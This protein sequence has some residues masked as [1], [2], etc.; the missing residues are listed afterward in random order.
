MLHARR[1]ARRPAR[2][3]RP[4]AS[5]TTSSTSRSRSGQHVIDDFVR[6]VP[7]GPDADSVHALQQRTQVRDAAR[8][9]RTASAP[10]T[11]RRG[12]TPGSR[13]TTG[14]GRHVLRRGVDPDKDQSYFLFS[15][16]QEQLS[17]AMFPVGAHDEG[18]GAE[19]TRGGAGSR[20]PRSADS[21]EICFVPGRRLR[22]L[23]RAR[24]PAR[25]RERPPASSPT[26]S[27]R[28]LGRHDGIHRFTVGQ[29]KRLR[30][31]RL[32][33]RC[34]VTAIDAP[35][36]TVVVGPREALERTRFDVSDVNWIAGDA[37]VAP[38][39]VARADPPPAPRGRGHGRRDR[40]ASG[41]TWSSTNRSRRSR[42]ARPRSSTT[43][44][45][46]LGGAGF[47]SQSSV[48]SFRRPVAG[49]RAPRASLEH[50]RYARRVRARD[51]RA[52]AASVE[53]GRR[54]FTPADG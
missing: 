53:Q 44:T 35:S 40:L 9:R 28:V 5:R 52:E 16:T 46:C 17:R 27:G 29:R 1:P 8:A 4:S 3:R 30:A 31:R 25:R 10:R 23:R 50:A 24:R 39:R 47:S 21:H 45:R 20:S 41:S 37:P 33:C 14:V 15:L 26:R 34:Y 43:A 13:G 6:R 32:A 49:C 11:S 36:H 18:R 22:G 12:T 7:R 54:P 38:L 2:G 51:R 42:P 19:P 48:F